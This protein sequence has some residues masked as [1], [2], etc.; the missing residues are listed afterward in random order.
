MRDHKAGAPVHER[1]HRLHDVALRTRVHARRRLIQNEDRRV[2]QNH[3]RDGEQLTLALADGLGIVFDMRVV[4]LRHR[5]DEV[6][7]MCH[8]GRTHDL[9]A[10]GIGTAIGDVLVSA[11]RTISSRVA[12]GRP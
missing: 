6:V 7:H 11:A 12:S 8:L 4:A 2:T 3:A 9:L 1:L 10:S 5:A